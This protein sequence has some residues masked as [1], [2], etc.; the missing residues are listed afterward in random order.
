MAPDCKGPR[1]TAGFLRYKG[2]R[3]RPAGLEL[4]QHHPRVASSPVGVVPDLLSVKAP[5]ADVPDLER[6]RRLIGIGNT[7]PEPSELRGCPLAPLQHVRATK[8]CAQKPALTGFAGDE[9]GVERNVTKLLDRVVR[10]FPAGCHSV[11]R[12]QRRSAI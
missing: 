11:Y 2:V 10:R 4:A 3:G 7:A 9:Y 8:V 12:K 5:T 6:D 1:Y